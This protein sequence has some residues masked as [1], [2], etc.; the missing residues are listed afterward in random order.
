MKLQTK[1]SAFFLTLSLALFLTIGDGLLAQS[2]LPESGAGLSAS[3]QK[4]HFGIQ[5]PIW[6]GSKFSLAP[7]V[8]A[9]YVDDVGADFQIG[10]IPKFYLKKQTVSPYFGI[11]VGALFSAPEKGEGTTDFV[12]GVACGVEY[13]INQNFSI[14]IEAELNGAV[15]DE[16]SMRF[17]NP[18]GFSLNT[19]TGFLATIYF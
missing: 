2:E 11:L 17:N 15:S 7:A 3:F 10:L 6:L 1:R 4:E 14:A 16:N 12:F 18:G 8:S 13:F 19:A 5:L 9:V